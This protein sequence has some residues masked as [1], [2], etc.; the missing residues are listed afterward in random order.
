MWWTTKEKPAIDAWKRK[1]AFFPTIIGQD[2][3]GR[4]R[5]VWLRIYEAQYTSIYCEVRRCEGL[6]VVSMIEF[7]CSTSDH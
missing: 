3:E 4:M 1:F 7:D 5:W 6:P 2:K